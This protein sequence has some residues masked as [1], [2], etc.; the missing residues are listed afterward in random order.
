MIGCLDCYESKKNT[1]KGRK[2]I[3]PSAQTQPR[4][5]Q[6]AGFKDILTNFP[7]NFSRFQQVKNM[8][9]PILHHKFVVLRT[10]QQQP[11]GVKGKPLFTHGF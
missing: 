3:A 6:K 5:I 1:Q 7:L 2:A 4:T 10:M 9:T 11:D 8:T